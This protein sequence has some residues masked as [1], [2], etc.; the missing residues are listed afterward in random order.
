MFDLRSPVWNT[1][2]IFITV[3]FVLYCWKPY[4]LFDVNGSMKS[5]GIGKDQTCFTFATVTFAIA[6]MT[7]F[8]FTLFSGSSQSRLKTLENQGMCCQHHPKS[9]APSSAIRSILKSNSRMNCDS[10]F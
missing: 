2:F 5:F 3:S 7:F 8:L 9:L 6:L 1:I 10:I 4:P